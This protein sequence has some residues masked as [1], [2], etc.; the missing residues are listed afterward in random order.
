MLSREVLVSTFG[1]LSSTP[2]HIHLL[3]ITTL[4]DRI[5]GPVR[6]LGNESES[7]REN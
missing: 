2:S 7:E 3:K 5:S 1:T 4:A 6:L